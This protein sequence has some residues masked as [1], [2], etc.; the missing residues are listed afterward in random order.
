MKESSVGST[1]EIAKIIGALMATTVPAKAHAFSFFPSEAQKGVDAV[2]SYQKNIY[3]LVNMLKPNM[4]PNALGVY[5][6]QQ[7]LKGGKDDS[8]VVLLYNINY[9]IPLQKKMDEVAP[10]LK[11]DAETQERVETLPK[12]MLGHSLELKEAIKSQKADEQL[13]EVEEVFETLNEFL[14][15]ASKKYEVQRYVDVKQIS[16]KDLYGP[17]GCEFWGKDRAEG[18]NACV[19]KA[20]SGK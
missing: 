17:L 16:D 18:S 10:K 13:K 8:D 1:V 15:L 19:E 2:A 11:L 5:S 14:D 3:E 9:V 6:M 4:V 20:K 12:L 7:Q